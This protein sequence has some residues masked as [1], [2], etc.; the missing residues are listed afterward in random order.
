MTTMCHLFFPKKI[1]R[2]GVAERFYVY[3]C[4]CMC[5]KCMYVHGFVSGIHIMNTYIFMGTIPAHKKDTEEKAGG[6]HF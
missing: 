3:V 4:V 5:A 2:F 6:F 1:P